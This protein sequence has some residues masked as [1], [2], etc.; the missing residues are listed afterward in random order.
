M[1]TIKTLYSSR[2]LELLSDPRKLTILRELMISPL[3]LTMLGQRMGK[4]PAWVRHHLKQLEAVGL[5]ELVDTRIQSGIV[6]KFYQS[7][8]GG[9]QLQQSILPESHGKPVVVFSGSHDLAVELL[10][11]QLAKH[12]FMLSLPIGSM[13]GLISLRQ[14]LCNIAGSHLLDV[15]GQYNTPFIRHIFPDRAM[16]IV[17][18]AYREQG[19]IIASGNP[20]SIRSL[21]DLER[22]DVCFVN[23]NV[24]SGTRLWLDQ[25]L[26]E[27]GIQSAKIRGYETT[28]STHTEAAIYVKH[29]KADVALGLKAAA[30]QYG[31]DFLPLL[32]ERYDVVF[33]F[34][35]VRLLAPFIEELNSGA[36]RRKMDGLA[37]YETFHTGEQV[38][39]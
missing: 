14:N 37:G 10:A 23:R 31:L 20:K 30:S 11:N 19:L 27:H 3:S 34:D 5:V 39:M 2:H 1:R 9:Y 7:T 25:Q 12:F 32:H 17:T 13:D 22:T 38:I 28:V 21:E 8:A 24:G 18:L 33:P 16:Q 35:Q 6:E 36:F 4:H 26:Q 29:E 15:N